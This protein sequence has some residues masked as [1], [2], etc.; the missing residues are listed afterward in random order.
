MA[1][2]QQR[3]CLL[4]LVQDVLRTYRPEWFAETNTEEPSVDDG[5]RNASENGEESLCSIDT[6]FGEDAEVCP[7]LCRAS[8]KRFF[9]KALRSMEPSA[10]RSTPYLFDRIESVIESSQSLAGFLAG[11]QSD[12]HKSVELTD[13]VQFLANGLSDLT[14]LRVQAISD[15]GFQQFFSQFTRELTRKPTFRKRAEIHRQAVANRRFHQQRDE[16]NWTYPGHQVC[17]TS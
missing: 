13:K 15:S 11:R 2:H 16:C 9:L 12:P 3:R 10:A 5:D 8:A 4:G 14:V 1:L 6:C 7:A 17:C